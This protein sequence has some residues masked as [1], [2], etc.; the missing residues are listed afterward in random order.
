MYDRLAYRD[1]LVY[2]TV[3][4]LAIRSLQAVL[5]GARPVTLRSYYFTPTIDSCA[6]S[7]STFCHVD[8]NRRCAY[9]M[10]F[11]SA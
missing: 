5:S 10:I 6:D 3:S 8:E 9:A 1:G 4:T 11:I 7:Y 2:Q